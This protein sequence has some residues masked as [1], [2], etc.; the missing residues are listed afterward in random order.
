MKNGQG[1]QCYRMDSSKFGPGVQA[2]LTSGQFGRPLQGQGPQF[3][4]IGSNQLGSGVQG[5]GSAVQGVGGS[6]H[7]LKATYEQDWRGVPQRHQ[8]AS[9]VGTANFGSRV[10][11]VG[12]SDDFDSKYDQAWNEI[13]IEDHYELNNLGMCGTC[14]APGQ[15]VLQ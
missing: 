8:I 2:P 13:E 10:G 4:R 9:A 15:C 5:F 6:S 14:G 12:G 3:H 11:V 7:S 1:P